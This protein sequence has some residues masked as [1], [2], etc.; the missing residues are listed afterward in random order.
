MGRIEEVGTDAQAVYALVQ[1]E[2]FD[3]TAEEIREAFLEEHGSQLTPEQL[4]A[5]A[6]GASGD[7]DSGTGI[8]IGVGAGVG[9]IVVGGGIAAGA[10]AAGAV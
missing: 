4:E 5:I 9:A 8:A 3:C 7:F 1:S 10:I 2:G 6:G